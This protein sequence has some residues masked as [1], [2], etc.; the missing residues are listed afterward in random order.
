MDVH[1]PNPALDTV[2]I[3]ISVLHQRG[4]L[5]D[6]GMAMLVER[7]ELSEFHDIADRVQALPI[8]NMLDPRT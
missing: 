1:P 3:L 5:D 8:M 7:L 2:L 6:V 4:V